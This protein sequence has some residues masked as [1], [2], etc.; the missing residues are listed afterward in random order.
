M[1]K[2][3]L[4]SDRYIV[5]FSVIIFIN[6]IFSGCYSIRETTLSDD[7]ITKIYE[8][9]T[10][11]NELID[12][13]DNKMGYAVLSNNEVISIKKNGDKELYQK[14]NIKKYYTKKFSTIKTLG[15]ITVSMLVLL[16]LAYVI[17]VT[18][19]KNT[20]KWGD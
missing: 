20:D 13:S 15:L 14:K 10:L 17:I 16:P 4:L 9:E 2:Y 5:S 11:D 6:L 3:M 1:K 19:T 7:E 18:Q 12:F 8:I